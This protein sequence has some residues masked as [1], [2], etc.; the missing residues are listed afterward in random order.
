[1]SAFGG[2]VV[3][4]GV[5][6][7][8]VGRRLGRSGV[9]LATE[10]ALAAIADA[11]LRPDDIDGISSYPGVFPGSG[12][13]AGA[14]VADVRN[15]LGLQTSWHSG[16]IEGA[17]QFG[18]VF[19]A[20]AA[21][22]SGLATHILTFRAVCESSAPLRMRPEAMAD[23]RAEG[24]YEWTVPYGAPSA[25]IWTALFANR[26]MHDFGLTREQLG[27]VAVNARRNAAL[28]PH[29]VYT[30][31]LSLEQYLDARMISYPFGL[32]DCDAPTD[33][34]TAVI[35]SRRE[36]STGL[37]RPPLTV[38]AVGSTYLERDTWDQRRDLT[39]MACHD[40]TSRIWD[41]T[42]LRPG[43]VDVAGLYDGFSYLTLQWLEA[44]GF[45]EHGQAG[46]F[47]DGGE[48]IARD[49]EL[50]LNTDGGQL[51]GGRL[52]GFGFLHEV[53]LQLWGDAGARQV[54]GDPGVAAVG[55]G[56]GPVAGAMLLTR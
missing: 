3:L 21:V 8:E 30:D 19:N 1:M 11:G 25:A 16:G 37:A 35:V 52:H 55:V 28:N 43:D 27:W 26:Y 50:P 9:D 29:A 36:A 46:R 48:R 34:A 14:A 41:E 32:F 15:A 56:G 42:S 53:C 44:F 7:S 38:E 10:A 5:G 18:P 23:P 24:A 45:C 54:G 22:A 39:T 20:C 47:V 31:P 17:A 51:S 49:G 6:Q 40:A 2:S 33:G 13:F 4:T 12:G